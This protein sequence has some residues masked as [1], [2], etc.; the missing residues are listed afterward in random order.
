MAAEKRAQDK[1]KGPGGRPRGLPKTGGRRK[2]TVNRATEVG[3]AYVQKHSRDIA[4]LCD[5]AAGRQIWVAD[6]KDP[7][8]RIKVYPSMDARLAAASKTVVLHVP[9]MKAIEI[10][11]LD[12]NAPFVFQFIS[13]GQQ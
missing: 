13:G 6:P 11:G 7:T 10:G 5:V 4:T 9:A 2:G 8:K 1:P 3:R 12:G